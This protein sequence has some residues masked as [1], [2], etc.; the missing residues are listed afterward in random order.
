MRERVA[1]YS[2]D[3]I[4][5]VVWRSGFLPIAIVVQGRGRFFA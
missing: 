2:M 4:L 1:G 3:Y 5:G